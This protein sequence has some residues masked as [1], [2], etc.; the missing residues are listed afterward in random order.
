MSQAI[1]VPEDLD[2]VRDAAVIFQMILRAGPSKRQA[3]DVLHRNPE[4]A[5]VA[6][7]KGDDALGLSPKG[8]ADIL[9]EV[10]GGLEHAKAVEIIKQH[11][12]TDRL[13]ELILGRGDLP[14]VI[15]EIAD[16]SVIIQAVTA[17]I[18]PFNLKVVE[19][20]DMDLVD[21]SSESFW[22]LRSWA[23]K[24]C[25][26]KDYETFLN[27][28]YGRSTLRDYVLVAVWFEAGCPTSMDHMTYDL[29][30]DLNL[31]PL[32]SLERL[33]QLIDRGVPQYTEDDIALE[34]AKQAE[35]RMENEAAP[36][37]TEEVRREAEKAAEALDL[38]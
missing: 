9:D 4:R 1:I 35:R 12:T 21:A 23:M 33:A 20:Q 26:R 37:V 32:E 25:G 10:V 14:A 28:S 3:L 22:V 2:G 11:L 13:S 16:M 17:Q 7:A 24:L 34:K 27:A 8:S 31:D 5:L 15:T 19:E 18:Q 36:T 6:L 30:M 29:F 38:G